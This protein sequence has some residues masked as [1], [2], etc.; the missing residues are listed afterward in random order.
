MRVVVVTPPAA[1][2]STV[3]Q[4]AH[5]RVEH[6]DDD[7]FIAACISAATSHIDGPAGW[8]GRAIGQQTLQV[9]LDEFD[10]TMPLPFP[11]VISVS[12]VTYLDTAEAQQTLATSVYEVQGDR[13]VLAANQSWPSRSSQPESVRVSYVAG[14]ATIPAAILAAIK[15][16]TADLYAHR[17]SAAVGSPTAVNM[18]VTV[19]RLLA[20]FRVWSL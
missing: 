6:S 7:T 18:S 11:P 12:A 8:L 13:V 1:V 14:Y 15:I 16:M 2:V 5:L 3:D 19:Q 10:D 17:E 9:R 20:P 4:K